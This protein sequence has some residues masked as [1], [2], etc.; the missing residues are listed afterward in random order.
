MSSLHALM[1]CAHNHLEK[2]LDIF[3]N[4]TKSNGSMKITNNLLAFI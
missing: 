3:L 1:A 2:E 4:S